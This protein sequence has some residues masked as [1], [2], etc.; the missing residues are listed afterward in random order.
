MVLLCLGLHQA[1][2]ISMKVEEGNE[3]EELEEMEKPL[4]LLETVPISAEAKYEFYQRNTAFTAMKAYQMT[5]AASFSHLPK[6]ASNKAAKA[7]WIRS[8]GR[9]GASTIYDLILQAVDDEK[10]FSLFEPCA[11]KDET[12]K[13]VDFMDDLQKCHFDEIDQLLHWRNRDSASEAK[14]YGKLTATYEC[15]KAGLRV[16]KTQNKHNLHLSAKQIPLGMVGKEHQDILIVNVVRDPRAIWASQK[17]GT[18]KGVFTGEWEPEDICNTLN[19]NSDVGTHKKIITIKFEDLVNK[20]LSAGNKLYAALGLEF[21]EKHRKWISEQFGKH[22]DCPE[23]ALSTCKRDSQTSLSKW[24]QVIDP[25]TARKFSSN[26]CRNVF[27]RYGYQ[28]DDDAFPG[29]KV[30]RQ[31]GAQTALLYQ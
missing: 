30:K 9:S 18:Q 6:N 5:G 10:L 25:N 26:T 11:H 31:T 19:H 23:T 24:K 3:I 4:D 20:P 1:V 7:I 8:I 27:T 12:P 16:F 28:F 29:L 14:S 15:E 2:R 17:L 13:C 21:A 22:P